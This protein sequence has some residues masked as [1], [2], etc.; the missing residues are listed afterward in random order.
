MIEKIDF[1]FGSSEEA[2]NLSLEP[3][4]MTVFVGPNHSGKSLSLSEIAKNITG[5]EG[6]SIRNINTDDVDLGYL[7]NRVEPQDNEKSLGELGEDEGIEVRNRSLVGSGLGTSR[8][9]SNLGSFKSAVES[10]H[11]RLREIALRSLVL[12]LDGEKRLK[13]L[14]N[15]GLGDLKAAP[16]NHLMALFK[17]ESSRR[18]VQE[19]ILETFGRFFAID[20]TGGNL[21]VRLANEKPENEHVETGLNEEAIEYY[22]GEPSIDSF[23][24]GVKAFAGI[25]S[26]VMSSQYR[27]AL[28]DEPD[29]F[30]HPPLSKKL[31]RFLTDTASE[32]EGN[33]FAATHDSN[34]LVGCV[35]AGRK[36]NVVRL[37]YNE[38]EDLATARLLE[39]NRLQEMMQDPILRSTD[40]LS[41][42]FH[43]GAVVCEGDVDR[44][45]YE[46][47]DLRMRREEEE[48]KDTVFLNAIGKDTIGDIV[49]P[50]R[51]M[52][53]PAAAVV[54]LDIVKQGSL[55]RLMRAA[56]AS[57][58]LVQNLG[59]RKKKVK[60]AFD[61][62]GADPKEGVG[63]L[64]PEDRELVRDLR[65]SAATFG[66]FI[67]PVGEVEDWLKWLDTPKRKR[68]WLKESFQ[69][70]GADPESKEYVTP[71][72]G[73]VW[74]FVRSIREW[75]SNPNREGIPK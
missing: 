17:D 55:T 30:L 65:E 32:R 13:L 63:V 9:R 75:I 12:W 47:V 5:G 62:V 73:D 19:I 24:D 71:S 46:E 1:Q 49:A 61:E 50:L 3:G 42:L 52:G 31:G 34:F 22:D 51:E 27:C 29:A 37:T 45:F 6:K 35:Q 25:L 4:P 60:N 14:N 69:Q 38:S 23:S 26:A 70:M 11:S 8:Y 2:D 58:R 66:V 21:V 57:D 20:P 28:V 64:Q 72:E 67:V 48:E 54:D 59:D 53:V 41:A 36:V 16:R 15:K 40:V 7:W 56:G 43:Q 33:V 68:D 39:G 18:K 74:D 44:A 10:G